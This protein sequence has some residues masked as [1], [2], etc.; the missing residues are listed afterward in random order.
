MLMALFMRMSYIHRVTMAVHVRPAA[1]F[2]RRR[3]LQGQQQELYIHLFFLHSTIVPVYLM[4]KLDH[5]VSFVQQTYGRVVK[6]IV[7]GMMLIMQEICFN[8]TMIWVLQ[9][10]VDC[11]KDDIYLPRKSAPACKSSPVWNLRKACAACCGYC[12]C[13]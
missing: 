8:I 4:D 11:E 7:S 9:F 1:D 13:W 2:L 5:Y 3:V 10:H 12:Y 6:G